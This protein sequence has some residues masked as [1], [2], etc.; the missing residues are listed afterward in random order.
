MDEDRVLELLSTL[1]AFDT[2]S[3]DTNLPLVDW[4]Q[5]HLA[6]LGFRIDRVSDPTGE[7]AALFASIGPDGPDGIVLSGHTDVVPVDGQTWT[8]DPFRLRRNGGK[9]FGRGACDMKGF[10]AVCLA[11]A[12]QMA[13]ATLAR[14]IHLA[15]TY[16]EEVGCVGGRV[17]AEHLKAK[18]MSAQAC[19][20]GEP[21]LM[22]T[23]VG[24]KGKRSVRVRV[25][26]STCHS[27]LAPQGVNAVEFGAR[28]VAEVRRIADRLAA[29][30][31]RDDLYD[32]PH[33]T[34]HV[35]VFRG[36]TALNIV[37][38]EAEIVF[39]FRT[40]GADDP[41]ALVAEVERF[42]RTELEP[43]MGKVRPESGFDIE[44]FAGFPGLD[45]A[46]DAPVVRLAHAL[47]G[48]SG[49]T[50][51]AFGTEAG[52]F[53]TIAGIPS[54][55]IGP[56]SIEQAHKADE[57]IAVDELMRCGRFVERVIAQCEG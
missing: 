5:A 20:V 53:A 46:P 4:A 31:R 7:K 11:G 17:L 56:G 13:R 24:H 23:V 32:V 43:A 50:K 39:E 37:P 51:V 27:S 52:L 1:V 16:D 48:G 3:R 25:R 49:A 55:V 54:V 35:G 18:G 47:S 33:S 38:D 26:G 14:P 34:G 57:W 28:L 15:L 22:G 6:A 44:V 21:T 2:T 10:D 29:E 8:S 41:D 42:A 9:V 12:E 30:G 36:G 45:T 19:F 40:I